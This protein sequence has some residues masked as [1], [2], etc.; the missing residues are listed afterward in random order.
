MKIPLLPEAIALITGTL[1]VSQTMAAT[2]F[3][4]EIEPLLIRRCSECHGPDK[5]KANLRL[6]SRAAALQAAESGKVVLVVGKPEASELIRRV[7]ATDPDEVMPPK[8]PRLTPAEVASLTRWIREGALWPDS[9]TQKH[10]SFQ[11]PIRP[12][13]PENLPKTATLQNPIDRFIVARLAKEGL[14]QQPEADRANLI[15]RVS[16]DLTGLPPEP[17]EISAFLADKSPRAF[18]TLVDRLLAS[19]HYGEHMARGWLDLA[20]YADSNGYQVDLARS[21][22]PYRQWVIEAFNKN[23][24]FDQ[25][26]ID[27]LAGDLLPQPTL[28]QR[29]AT[30]FNR[31]TKVNDEGGGDAEEYRTKAVKDRVATVGMAWLGLTLNCAE[32]HTHKYDPITHEEYYRFYSFFNN[33]ADSGNYSLGPSVEVPKPDTADMDAHHAP[34]RRISPGKSS[35]T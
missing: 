23:Q 19:P 27:Q 10:W 26:T 32:C 20:R 9:N 12:N 25:F 29:I 13:P 30:G 4:A 18:E 35:G 11:A 34:H 33:S 24:P 15:R 8:G 22:W 31:N 14:Q 2:D 5:Q 21:I 7:T 3:T 28:A 16:L 17:S 1:L 6:D